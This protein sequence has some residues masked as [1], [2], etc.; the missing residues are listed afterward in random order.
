MIHSRGRAIYDP[1]TDGTLDIWL[2]ATDT[3]TIFDTGG[4]AITN[5]ATI[6]RW[7]SKAVA[8]SFRQ[9]AANGR[10]TWSSSGW[11]GLP[12]ARFNSQILTATS[13]AGYASLSG[14]TVMAAMFLVAPVSSN[15]CGFGITEPHETGNA[16]SSLVFTPLR[17]SVFFGGRRHQGDAFNSVGN[18]PLA[19]NTAVIVSGTLN[20]T[21]KTASD[22]KNGVEDVINGAFQTGG[23]GTTA[24]APDP[25]GISLGGFAQES[26]SS[27]GNPC[28]GWIAEI[29]VRKSVSTPDDTVGPHDYLCYR[30]GSGAM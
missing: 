27:I 24:A 10:P 30:W 6:G 12:A 2:D 5:G 28:N 20:F 4:A 17:E 21:G 16:D 22:Y 26:T 15:G 11:M 8:R 1:A 18:L 7:E 25:F 23:S 3:S 9:F 14:I 19:N 29:L 13:S